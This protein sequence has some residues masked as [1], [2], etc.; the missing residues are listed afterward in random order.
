VEKCPRYIWQWEHP[1][2]TLPP[3]VEPTRPSPPFNPFPT[4]DGSSQALCPRCSQLDTSL[5]KIASHRPFVQEDYDDGHSKRATRKT[6]QIPSL[7][8]VRTLLLLSTCSL[9]RLI[10]DSSYLTDEEM[11][12]VRFGGELVLVTGWTIYRLEKDLYWTG[13][14]RG[15]GPYAKCMYTSV[16]T[17]SWADGIYEPKRLVEEAVEAIGLIDIGECQPGGGPA[18]GVR[19]VNPTTPNYSVIKDWLRG[20]DS[21]HHITC[22]PFVSEDLKEMKLIDVE[23]RKIVRYPPDGCDYISLSYVWG[24][25]EQPGYKLGQILPIV[26]ATLEDAMIVTRNLGKQYLWADSLCIDQEN[27][28][29]KAAQIALMSAIYSGA[30]ATIICLSG[31]SARSG[32]PRV[33]TLQGVVPQLCCEIWGKRLSSVMPSLSQQISWSPWVSRAWTFQEGLLSPRRLFFTNHQVYF[34]CNSVQCCES[35]DDSNSPFHLPSDEQRRVALDAVVQDPDKSSIAGPEGV[36]GRGVFRDPFRPISSDVKAQV[37]D[38][39]FA[40]Y[41]RLVHSYTTKKISHDADS[42]NAFSAMLTRL[43]ENYYKA[44]FVQG[45]PVED[46]PRALLWFHPTLPRRR[47]DF[48]AWSWAGWEG[49]VSGTIVYGAEDPYDAVMPP[50]RIWKTGNDDHPEPVYNFN[51]TPDIIK[52]LEKLP[53]QD[54]ADD[55]EETDSWEEETDSWED[56][57]DSNSSSDSESSYDSDDEVSEGRDVTLWFGMEMAAHTASSSDSDDEHSFEEIYLGNDPIFRLA[58]TMLQETPATLPGIKGHELLIEGIV[59]RLSFMETPRDHYSDSETSDEYD[60]RC[61]IR[62]EG[63]PKP[64]RMRFYGQNAV[65]LANQRSNDQQEFLL[66]SRE[67]HQGAPQKIYNALLLIDRDGDVANRVGVASLRLDNVELL[68]SFQPE[69][70]RFRLR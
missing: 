23:T 29:E 14:G 44:G 51:P 47:L 21:L 49:G 68:D 45:L 36:I 65:Q 28:A 5:S 7:G 26:P 69:R 63:K 38:D 41:L 52:E 61:F 60:G 35:L 33:G 9:C 18:L 24:G 59:I 54:G 27:S 19:Q 16:T 62:L 11:E 55:E 31:R 15:K 2:S 4:I 37:D 25:V 64:Q 3:D 67:P 20:C 46:L 42:L 30:W 12:I 43:A 58:K 70:R 40:R 53:S 10:F 56:I 34:E 17:W 39:D 13:C 22:R 57:D 32:L 50:L 8:P 66:L 6:T 48:P 1:G